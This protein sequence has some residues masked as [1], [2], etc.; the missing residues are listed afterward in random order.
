VIWISQLT[1]G[2][3]S[4]PEF[5]ASA[6]NFHFCALPESLCVGLRDGESTAYHNWCVCTRWCDLQH[7]W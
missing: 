5:I 6:L 2:P 3:P 1:K 4:S 7:P